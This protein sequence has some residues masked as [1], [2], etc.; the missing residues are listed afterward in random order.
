[1]WGLEHPWYEYIVRAVIIY[2]SVFFLIRVMGKKQIGEMGPFDLV[3]LL[4]ISESVSSGIT[5]GDNSLSAA[6]ICAATFVV[7]N[8]FIDFLGFKSKKVEKLL[9]GEPKRIIHK[10]QLD[11]EI[12]RREF[13]TL[14][15]IASCLRE[16]GI[17]D[18]KEVDFAT[19]ETN[20]KITVVKE[21][22]NAAK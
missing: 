9:E 1:M 3:L 20:G 13:I 18:I 8:Y 17:K 14:D 12:C 21:A 2:A 6:L 11:F 22:A 7:G 4:I 16:H 19:L 5:G 10:G 15:E